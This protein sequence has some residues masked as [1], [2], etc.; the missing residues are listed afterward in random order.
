MILAAG[1]GSRLRPLTDTIP[2]PMLPIA[3]EPLLA[4]TIRW[5]KRYG[6]DQIAMNLHHLPEVVQNGLGDGS[7]WGV[8][9]FYMFEPELRG[10]AGAVKAF[11]QFWDEAF[12]VVYGD[13]LV[14]IDLAALLDYHRSRR[15]LVTIGLKPTDDP[16]SQGM[17]AL[18]SAG[19]LVRFA[20]KPA[21][22]PPDQR[23]ANAGI[24]IVESE[25][26]DHIPADRPSDWGADIFPLLI[27]QGAPIYGQLVDGQLIDIGTP[28]IYERI[29]NTGLRADSD[30][31]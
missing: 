26:L 24:Y 23:T 11:E 4:H 20:E 28:A 29:K 3:G 2:K 12:V 13:L 7:Q 25:A 6:I 18:D 9:L 5:L 10:T 21:H 30:A 1:V 19:K 31:A 14:D 8:Q 22:W 27:S 15:A 17:V 16:Q